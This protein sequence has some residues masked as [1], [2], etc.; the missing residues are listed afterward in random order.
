MIVYLTQI[1]AIPKLHYDKEK[2]Q[3]KN[4]TNDIEKDWKKDMHQNCLWQEAF[5]EQMNQKY[6]T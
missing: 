4:F 1:T 2:Q 3:I 6:L 5:S